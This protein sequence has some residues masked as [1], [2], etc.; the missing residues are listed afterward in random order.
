MEFFIPSIWLGSAMNLIYIGLRGISTKIL[1]TALHLYKESKCGDTC[2]F[3]KC[4]GCQNK[5]VKLR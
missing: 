2:L 5:V 1:A 3:G 4:D